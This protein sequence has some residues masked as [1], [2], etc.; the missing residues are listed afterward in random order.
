MRNISLD[1][2]SLLEILML[3]GQ[4]F[5][6][7]IPEIDLPSD[8]DQGTLFKFRLPAGMYVKPLGQSLLSPREVSERV[9]AVLHNDEE[10]SFL[11][12]KEKELLK[13]SKNKKRVT[14]LGAG[15]FFISY[16]EEDFYLIVRRAD[17][18]L[19]TEKLLELF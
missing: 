7:E 13:L 15:G 17:V 8:F 1:E 12:E 18:A 2:F 5:R 4:E 16:E 9:L 6:C 3:E 11:G 14:A 10:I 19:F